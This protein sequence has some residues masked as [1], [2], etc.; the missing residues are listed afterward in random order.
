M[1]E[2]ELNGVN[3]EIPA[4]QKRL[5]APKAFLDDGAQEAGRLNLEVERHGINVC[6]R[7]REIVP[8]LWMPPD[9]TVEFRQTFVPDT[10]RKA[11]A[12]QTQQV[13]D[14]QDTEPNQSQLDVRRP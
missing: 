13:A 4:G 10:T 11:A 3:R 14:G 1:A 8:N 2:L 7:S 6:L 9:G 12:R 5:Q